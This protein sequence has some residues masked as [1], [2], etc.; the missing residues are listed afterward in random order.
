M[1]G[2]L[3]LL[4]L[5]GGLVD[6][7]PAVADEPSPVVEAPAPPV[8]PLTSRLAALGGG[9]DGEVGI[10][11]RDIES[12]RISGWRADAL[13]PQQSVA[14]LW[15]ALAVLDAVDRG[16]LKLGDP[17]TVRRDDLSIF[18]QPIRRHVL[19]D[20][21][22]TASI[23]SMLKTALTQSD[24]A[25]NQVLVSCVGGPE[26][27]QA[28]LETKGM[29]EIRFG[30]GERVLQTRIAGMSTWRREFSYGRQ[31][32]RARAFV[33]KHARRKAMSDYLANPMD[34]AT[35]EAVA[36]ALARLKRGEL[37]SP[38]STRLLLS[39]M[40]ASETGPKRLRGGLRPGWSIAHKTGT[41]QVLD[42]TATGYNDVAI[43]TAP[44]GRSY[45][46]VVMIAQTERPVT[47]RQALM[48]AVAR[49]VVDWHDGRDPGG[50]VN[51]PATA[52]AG[53]ASRP[54]PTMMR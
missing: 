37:L 24:N 33:P 15:A 18:H 25:A 48:A 53:P 7:A 42:R 2:L 39:D 52:P 43:L 23:S 40:A 5:I 32:W 27:V 1:Q 19:E 31:F 28:V 21:A 51:G 45:A 35:P 20:G 8:D 34:G 44:D 9:F 49:A 38:A 26:A 29:G 47:E 14:K 13:L 41:G 12:D 6:R 10:A 16:E 50:A 30:P 46:V 54:E 36:A 22:Y 3:L 17:L 4:L 11:V